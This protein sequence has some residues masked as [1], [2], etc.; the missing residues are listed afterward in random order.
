M[1]ATTGR[2]WPTLSPSFWVSSSISLRRPASTTVK[3]TRINASDAARPT[4]VPAPVT[5]A[6]LFVAS[7]IV[8]SPYCCWLP[9]SFRFRLVGRPR[10]VLVRRAQRRRPARAQIVEIG[11]AGLDAVIEIGIANVG[12]HYKYVDRQAHA[13]IGAHG[14]VHRDQPGLERFVQ[15]DIVMHRAVQH[16]LAVFVLADLQ[17]R[18]VGGAL[19]EIAGGIDHEQPHARALD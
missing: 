6:I 14:R 11:F 16:R 19:D 5:T 3:P 10:D 1:S 4:P 9:F 15:L 7:A 18:R 12:A 8:S 17:V 2:L 13:E